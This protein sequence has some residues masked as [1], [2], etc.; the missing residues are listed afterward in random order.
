MKIRVSD[1]GGQAVWNGPFEGDPAFMAKQF[2]KMSE[3]RHTWATKKLLLLLLL[4]CAQGE[5]IT[6]SCPASRARDQGLHRPASHALTLEFLLAASVPVN[7][8]TSPRRHGKI[9]HEP[10]ASCTEGFA[11]TCR[12]ILHC[13]TG[14]RRLKSMTEEVRGSW[15]P[16]AAHN[17]SRVRK[18]R[19]SFY[20]CGSDYG[21][22]RLMR[23]SRD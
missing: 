11:Q 19:V 16:A 1:L 3:E 22:Y 18:W 10:E 13:R 4:Q 14:H 2:R 23:T 9:T 21:T 6:S 15:L 5:W 7:S 8:C 17:L 12:P 20:T